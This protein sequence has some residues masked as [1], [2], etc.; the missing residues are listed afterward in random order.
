M[1]NATDAPATHVFDSG[2]EFGSPVS[3]LPL[4]VLLGAAVF[5][6]VFICVLYHRRQQTRLT[7][8]LPF[9]VKRINVVSDKAKKYVPDKAR[10]QMLQQKCKPD[11]MPKPE[12]EDICRPMQGTLGP[13]TIYASSSEATVA[14]NT[15]I[16][17]HCETIHSNSSNPDD[18]LWAQYP[19]TG[20]QQNIVENTE[21][22]R[23]HY[24][25]AVRPVV[26]QNPRPFPPPNTP[27][28]TSS[29]VCS[30]SHRSTWGSVM[31]S[32]TTTSFN[33]NEDKH[34]KLSNHC[35]NTIITT[36]RGDSDMDELSSDGQVE[37]WV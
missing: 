22:L 6:L 27:I 34:G 7:R 9:R 2:P 11:A 18:V 19:P 25:A 1:V 32:H 35:T 33:I 4:L 14:M 23:K 13:E 31:N 5:V 12:I 21:V 10:K 16:E 29:G 17:A 20:L 24:N 30:I 37:K 36:S 8:Q 15:S 26:T 3:I 28:A